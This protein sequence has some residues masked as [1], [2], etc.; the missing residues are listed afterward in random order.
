M[1]TIDRFWRFVEKTDTCWLWK[2]AGSPGYGRFRA[3]P[4]SKKLTQA[5]RFAY[6]HLVGP[7]P[8]GLEIDH[9]CRNRACVNPAH[10][11]PVTPQI[12]QHRSESVSGLN[13]AKT[14]CARGHSFSDKRYLRVDPKTG[15]RYCRECCRVNMVAARAR[16]ALVKA[17][18][19]FYR[20]LG[21][22]SIEAGR[23]RL[24]SGQFA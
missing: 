13:A 16:R 14:H 18:N 5:H 9:L 12:N 23:E 21:L 17:P 6:E 11:E 3:T 22:L 7:I 10:L 4:G 8:A 15:K 19:P 2:G 20:N 1:T 24:P